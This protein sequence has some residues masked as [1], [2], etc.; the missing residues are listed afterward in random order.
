MIPLVSSECVIKGL[1]FL[2]TSIYVLVTYRDTQ[3]R[4]SSDPSLSEWDICWPV[5]TWYMSWHVAICLSVVSLPSKLFKLDVEEHDLSPPSP[6]WRRFTILLFWYLAGLP[7]A[8]VMRG[9]C[10]AEAPGTWGRALRVFIEGIVAFGLAGCIYGLGRCLL[11]AQPRSR[12]MVL[13][14]LPEKKS[15]APPGNEPHCAAVE[16]V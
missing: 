4:T 6:D 8:Y 11:P 10:S 12:V 1:F 2:L 13:P 15:P 3:D 7:V 14:F 9:T 16:T 5:A